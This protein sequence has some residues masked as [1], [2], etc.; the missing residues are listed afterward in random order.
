MFVSPNKEPFGLIYEYFES[1]G[2]HDP[3]EI[4]ESELERLFLPFFYR[5][6]RQGLVKAGRERNR[7]WHNTR[8]RFHDILRE[9]EYRPVPNTPD[10]I[11]RSDL[12]ELREDLKEVTQELAYEIA[13]DS[14]QHSTTDT[15]ACRIFFDELFKRSDYQL[16][17]SQRT[18]VTSF[19]KARETFVNDSVSLV[20]GIPSPEEYAQMQNIIREGEAAIAG[21]EEWANSFNSQNGKLDQSELHTIISACRLY[22]ED[23]FAGTGNDS[24][25]QYFREV[26]TV[27]QL[28][29]YE[30]RYKYHYLKF[31]DR[32]KN[33]LKK[34]LES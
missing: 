13:I 25:A 1:V 21:L 16:Y 33:D 9:P 5:H 14:L 6:I 32:L 24:L 4:L 23:V 7:Q 27:E 17:L 15:K 11:T 12:R 30:T 26:A 8:R 29:Q 18:L 10:S 22:L 20:S 34:V 31:V 3:T 19:V 2:V 28:S